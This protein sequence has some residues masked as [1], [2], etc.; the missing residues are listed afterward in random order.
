VCA[1]GTC[2]PYGKSGDSCDFPTDCAPPLTCISSKCATPLATGAHCDVTNTSFDAC[3]VF[4]GV[5]CDSE[6]SVCTPT[7]I[8]VGQCEISNGGVDTCGAGLYCSVNDSPPGTCTARAA[9]GQSCASSN[10][11]VTS[12]ACLPYATC[13]STSHTCVIQDPNL[14]AK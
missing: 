9:D 10:P 6:T 5:H 1:T 11:V 12:P 13:D 8:D 14:C 4:D 7:Q 2:K 3:D